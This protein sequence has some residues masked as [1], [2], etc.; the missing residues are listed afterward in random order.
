MSG[1]SPLSF[2]TG[3]HTVCHVG[4]CK[5]RLLSRGCLCARHMPCVRLKCQPASRLIVLSRALQQR[6]TRCSVA[7][8]CWTAPQPRAGLS[9]P[10]SATGRVYKQ[11]VC[12]TSDTPI[13]LLKSQLHHTTWQHS[14]QSGMELPSVS[15]NASSPARYVALPGSCCHYLFS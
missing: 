11:Q 9:Q 10:N 13:Q 4:K 12:N 2:T 6:S 8:G 3:A 7:H 1:L 14:I 15:H 5:G